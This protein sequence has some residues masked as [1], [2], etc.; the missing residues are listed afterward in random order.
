MATVEAPLHENVKQ[1]LVDGDEN[2]TVL[3]MRSM[4]NTERVYKN[5]AAMEVLD[6]EK[7]HPGDFSKI[8][9]IIKGENYRYICPSSLNN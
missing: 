9:H 7:Q 5:K 4:R 3:V 1:A 8:S 6:I 2:N